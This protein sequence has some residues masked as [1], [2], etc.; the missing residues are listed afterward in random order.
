MRKLDGE[1]RVAKLNIATESMLGD[2]GNMFSRVYNQPFFQ[3][4]TSRIDELFKTT[5]IDFDLRPG[6]DK[7][8][9]DWTNVQT[10]LVCGDIS[11]YAPVGL[12]TSFLKYIEVLERQLPHFLKLGDELIAPTQRLIGALL[13]DPELVSSKSGMRGRDFVGKLTAVSIEGV[14]GEIAACFDPNG[15]SDTIPYKQAY[16]RNADIE[17]AHVRCLQMQDNII[18]VDMDQMENSIRE[19]FKQSE[20]LSE[21]IRTDVKYSGITD[22]VTKQLS[23]ILYTNARWVELF[24]VYR[25]Q[26][27]VLSTALEDTKIKLSEKAG[28]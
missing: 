19:L 20:K 28:I 7:R 12:K 9:I 8:I 2:W 16:A 4:A 18:R 27:I 25:R 5:N 1:I 11:V 14:A 3:R 17:A 10:Y 15:V 22:S 6:Y 13:V 23:D 24:A 26:I 21:L